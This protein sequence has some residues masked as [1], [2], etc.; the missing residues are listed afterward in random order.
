MNTNTTPEN[1]LNKPLTDIEK[2]ISYIENDSEIQ[3]P[4][5]RF[6]NKDGSHI[7]KKEYGKILLEILCKELRD[8]FC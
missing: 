7:T 3:I 8:K 1:N 6:F 4:I 2:I 5:E